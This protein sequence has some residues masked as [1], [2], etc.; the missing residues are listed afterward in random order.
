MSMEL[1]TFLDPLRKWWWLILASTVIAAVTSFFAVSRQ[2]PVYRA[3]AILLIGSAINNP[4]PTGFEL[5]LS[6]QLAETY[7]DIAQLEVV[8]EAVKEKLGLNWLPSYTASVFTNSQLIEVAVTDSSPERAMVVANELAN[9]L[10]NQT[11]TNTQDDEEAERQAFI[12]SQLDDLENSIKETK[13]SIVAKQ[14]ELAGLFSA[15][16][17]ADAQT[18]IAAL[19][20]KLNTLQSNYASLSA[21]TSQR[22]VNSLKV[23]QPATIP[24]QQVGPEILMTVL[25]AAAIGMA[26]AVGAAYLLEYLDDTLKNP[27]DIQRVSNLPT[28]AGIAEFKSGN[29]HSNP[30]ITFTHP[31]SPISE[32]Y[33]SLRTAVQF[34]DV[35]NKIRTILITSPSPSEGKSTTAANLAVV[36]AQAGHRVLLIDADFRKPVQHKIF[37]IEKNYGLT[38]IL[39]EMTS[40]FEPTELVDFF[41]HVNRAAIKTAQTGLSVI[42]S[43]P[44]PPNPAEVIGSAKMKLLIQLLTTRF[45]YVV[46]DSPPILAVT[47]AVV[48]NT[49]VDRS[50][51][52]A[53]SGRTRR[54]QLKQVV[55]RLQEVRSNNIAGVVLNRLTQSSGEY[56]HYYY[57][58]GYYG[59]QV[60][61]SHKSESKKTKQSQAGQGGQVRR[62]PLVDFFARL[63]S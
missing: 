10:V 37:G 41:I 31:R 13:D 7:T 50:I 45:D 19:N 11:P 21:G 52:V 62:G 16:Q 5:R 38:N 44:L 3:R 48:L 8:R 4:N 28:L 1:K 25:T 56:Y 23:I 53:S 42:P 18:Q 30:L 47:D 9:Q 57:Q 58:S 2:P 20:N 36:M 22:A 32:A 51:I 17:I 39:V 29:G 15:R 63:L 6:E 14:E 26:L 43:G 33:R 49:R 46:I 40:A 34:S 12:R 24:E 55:Q 61:D 35:D 27:D 54:N 59:D 60:D